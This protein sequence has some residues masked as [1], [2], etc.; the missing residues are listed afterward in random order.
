MLGNLFEQIYQFFDFTD[1]SCSETFLSKYIDFLILSIYLTRKPF[2]A[3]ILIFWF[4]NISR[5]KTF[6]SKYINFLML[7]IYLAWK[8]FWANKSIFWFY[9]YISLGNLFDQI[10]QFFDFIDISCSKAF[11]SQYIDIP[12]WVQYLAKNILSKRKKK[13]MS[14]IV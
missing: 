6:S 14:F 3:N 12:D 1:I 8:P 4:I 10:Y 5:S 9:W 7:L 11:S 2:R 13:K